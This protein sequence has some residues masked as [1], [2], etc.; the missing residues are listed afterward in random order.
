MFLRAQFA[1]GSGVLRKHAANR[2]PARFAV[3]RAV[4][5]TLPVYAY[6]VSH[7]FF[8]FKF[9]VCEYLYTAGERASVRVRGLPPASALRLPCL[10]QSLVFGCVLEAMAL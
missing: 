7:V 4:P 2:A 10:R 5:L 9:G 6:G 3:S 8:L 1:Q